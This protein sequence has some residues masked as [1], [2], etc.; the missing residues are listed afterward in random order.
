MLCTVNKHNIFLKSYYRSTYRSISFAH[1]EKLFR[2]EQWLEDLQKLSSFMDDQ[3][4][5]ETWRCCF[6][7]DCRSN[8][9][10]G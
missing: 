2:F 8:P 7:Q 4:I 10:N 3:L 6:L 9:R 1:L 5:D